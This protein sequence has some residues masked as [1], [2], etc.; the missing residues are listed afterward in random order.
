VVSAPSLLL[1]PRRFAL[2][3]APALVLSSSPV[4]VFFF[5]L[6]MVKQIARQKEERKRA[7][8]RRA[9]TTCLFASCEMVPRCNEGEE[10][11]SQ[12]ERRTA[13]TQDQSCV[14]ES[15]GTDA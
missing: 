11:L 2:S 7:E 4:L 12:R 6:L 14:L 15:R 9:F 1:L 13:A 10:K 8:V 3:G 5:L